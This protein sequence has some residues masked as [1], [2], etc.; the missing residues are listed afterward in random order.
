MY[1]TG[2]F[3]IVIILLRFATK[4]ARLQLKVIVIEFHKF[5]YVKYFYFTYIFNVVFSID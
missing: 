3:S 5:M 2:T 4:T 1:S